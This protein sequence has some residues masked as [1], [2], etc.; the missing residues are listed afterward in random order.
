MRL[1]RHRAISAVLAVVLFPV[2]TWSAKVEMPEWSEDAEA[3]TFEL[4]GGLWPTDIVSFAEEALGLDEEGDKEGLL[5]D[6]AASEESETKPADQSICGS[7]HAR[8]SN[9]ACVRAMMKSF[10]AV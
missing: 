1:T 10:A 2:T 7:P 5:A 9:L 4:G 3:D 8:L 6:K